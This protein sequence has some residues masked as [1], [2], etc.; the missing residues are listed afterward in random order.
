[1]V[2]PSKTNVTSIVTGKVIDPFG[3]PVPNLQVNLT[4]NPFSVFLTNKTLADGTF[5]FV[6]S[7]TQPN[8][9]YN[10]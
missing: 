9:T 8:E 10:F 1:M 2:T 4:S 5:E 3:A 7:F 6:N